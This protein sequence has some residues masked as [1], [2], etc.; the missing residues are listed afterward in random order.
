MRAGIALA[1]VCALLWLTSTCH[2]CNSRSS[3]DPI[4]E[5][6]NDDPEQQ[7]QD[8][9]DEDDETAE[10]ISLDDEDFDLMCEGYEAPTRTQATPGVIIIGSKK[11]GTR[12]LIEF[13]KLH[14]SIKAAGPE[15][16]Y[17]D[18]NYDKGVDW[19]ISKMPPVTGDQLA[20]EKTPGYF[21]TPDAPRR[22]HSMDPDVKMLLVLRDPVRRLISDYNQFRSRH[23]EQGS[24]YP[25][26][27]D[28]VFTKNGDVDAQYPPVQRSMYHVHMSRWLMHFPAKQIHIVHGEKFIK[29]P[30]VEMQMVEQYLNVTS[31]IGENNFFFNQTKGFYCGRDIRTRGVW[32][33]TKEKCLSKSK[34]RPKPPL[35]EGTV[36]KLVEYFQPHNEL[37]Y[38]LLG[39]NFGWPGA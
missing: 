23:V 30:W 14:P 38:K 19:Y 13:L 37:F 29:Q 28:L 22:V 5:E 18:N 1:F 20:V 24:V 21:H 25:D 10:D 12:A 15:I 35:R 8:P 36:E 9:N 33:C 7:Q 6:Q 17:F 26:L 31:I 32:Q 2:C 16:H 4:E 3:T 34:G 39:R 27:E 11:G